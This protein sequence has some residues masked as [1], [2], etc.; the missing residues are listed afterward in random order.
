MVG[1]YNIIGRAID[2][3]VVWKTVVFML[4]D[5]LAHLCRGGALYV[6]LALSVQYSILTNI[7]KG[8]KEVEMYLQ[9]VLKLDPGVSNH[10]EF[11]HVWTD[12]YT[13]NLN[14]L[15][16]Y[17]AQMSLFMQMA[18][19]QSSGYKVRRRSVVYGCICCC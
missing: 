7:V 10:F 1:G 14:L 4:L 12:R 18:Q 13:D 3:T 6:L 17:E 8:M 2:G 15:Y 19:M 16:R 9:Y 11:G 5:L